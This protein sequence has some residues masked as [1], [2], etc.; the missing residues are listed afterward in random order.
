[1]SLWHVDESSAD[2]CSTHGSHGRGEQVNK[3]VA[4]KTCLWINIQVL[5]EI[6]EFIIIT[7]L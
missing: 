3:S 5:S 1:M 6:Y 4:K 7:L 2:N